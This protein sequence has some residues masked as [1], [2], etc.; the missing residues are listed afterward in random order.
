MA[1][2]SMESLLKIPGHWLKARLEVMIM[3]PRS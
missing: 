2:V 3:E 1:E